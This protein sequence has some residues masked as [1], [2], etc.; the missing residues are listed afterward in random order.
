MCSFSP[1][2]LEFILL[3]IVCILLC[4]WEKSLKLNC[5]Y[6]VFGQDAAVIQQL[7]AIR[8]QYLFP[9]MYAYRNLTEH[10]YPRFQK[11]QSNWIAADIP[12]KNVAVIWSVNDLL[13]F[14]L[15]EDNTLSHHS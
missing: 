5:P 6:V 15:P 7:R 13:Y 14:A 11:F 3:I 10:M 12:S 1:I 9:T 4:R 2:V 8:Q